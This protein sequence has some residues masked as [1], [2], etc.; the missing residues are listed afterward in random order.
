MFHS[1]TL[2]LTGWYLLILMSI[3]ILFSFTIYTAATGEVGNRLNDFQD[4]LQQ[5][6]TVPNMGSNPRLFSAFR[7]DQRETAEHNLFATLIYVNILILFG[8]GILSYI[9]ARRTL[10][11]I[12]ESHDAQS[13]FVS[14]VSHELRTPLAAMKAELEVALL[15]QKLSKS[16]MN[17]LLKSNL[18]E[19]DKLTALSQT[20]LQLSKLDHA[21]LK[22][23]NLDLAVITNEVAQRYDK[24]LKRIKV[25]ITAK[26]SIIRANRSSVEELV[27]ILIDNALKYS[28][29]GSAVTIRLSQRGN[30]YTLFEITNKGN[31]IAPDDLPHIFDRFYRADTSRSTGGTGLGLSLAKKIVEMLHGELSV[32]SAVNHDT[33]FRVQLPMFKENK[34]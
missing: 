34:A 3:S 2:K 17:E 31:G 14:D 11:Q 1:A 15:D 12:E 19:V 8:G 21:S 28:P 33:T 32:S 27:T 20:L 30:R 6:G 13:R 22:V 18:E 16:D 10:R 5:P 26:Q 7:Q 24:N 25:T 29:A 9:L 4:R 23:E